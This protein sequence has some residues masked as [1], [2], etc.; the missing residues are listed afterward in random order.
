MFRLSKDTM[1]RLYKYMYT[2][3]KQCL[4]YVRTQY[5]GYVKT[6][7]YGYVKTPCSPGDI[8]K[9]SVMFS[10]AI[11]CISDVRFTFLPTV[12]GTR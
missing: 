12:G 2:M 7:C 8:K 1:F 6:Q 4:G 5:L 11:F 9:V 3:F 10:G